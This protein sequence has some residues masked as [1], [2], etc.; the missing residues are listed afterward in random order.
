MNRPV[1]VLIAVILLWGLVGCNN[2]DDDDDSN[3]QNQQGQSQDVFFDFRI[4]GTQYSTMD[5][6]TAS[7]NGFIEVNAQFSSDAGIELSFSSIPEVGSVQTNIAN[8]FSFASSTEAWFCNDACT[9]TITESEEST[10]YIKG[11]ISGEMS[12]LFGGNS[13]DIQEAE[14]G[15]FYE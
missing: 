3:N 12:D 7:A 4:E 11:S 10:S 9:I 15:F 2:D 8:G 13:I 14:F 1:K 6:V 5:V